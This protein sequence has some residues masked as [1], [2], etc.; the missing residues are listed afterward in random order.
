MNELFRPE[1]IGENLKMS[2]L[3]LMNKIKDKI[4]SPKLTQI[5]NIYSFY[6]G[7]NSRLDLN[8]ERGIFILSILRTIK[9]KLIYKDIYETVDKN[10]SDSQV[11]GRKKRS[12]RNNLFILYSIM[13]DARAS[14]KIIDVNFYD[15]E[16]CFDSLWLD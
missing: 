13:H 5:C 12:I 3:L 2:I 6:K 8:N 15:V 9:E 1:F 10:M 7:K 11:G 14:K 4:N 16:K